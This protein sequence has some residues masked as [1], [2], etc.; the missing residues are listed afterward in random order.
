MLEMIVRDMCI[1]SPE[2]F[3]GELAE[4]CA[5]LDSRYQQ[6]NLELPQLTD[7]LC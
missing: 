4:L 1:V 5:V 7:Y 2:A 6:A 3:T